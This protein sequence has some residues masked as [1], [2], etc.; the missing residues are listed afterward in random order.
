T[1]SVVS[2]PANGALSGTPPNL[3]YTPDANFN[4]SDSFTFK[5]NDGELDS[6]PATVS[7]TVTPVNDAPVADNQSVNTLEDTPVAITLTGSDVE[8]SALTF[9]ILSSPANGALSGSP[10]N[11]TYT[12]KSNFNGSDSFTF[13]VNDGELDS[14]PA[15]VSINVTHVNAGP[16]ISDIPDQTIHKNSTTGPIA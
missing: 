13:K 5:V 7:I 10:P 12:P 15:T 8:G 14:A 11:L 9:T 2:N 16:T 1:F 3:T 6:A 4:G